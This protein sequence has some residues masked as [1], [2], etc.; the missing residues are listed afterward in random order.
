MPQTNII[1]GRSQRGSALI[2]SS[3]VLLTFL[4][5]LIGIVDFGQILFTHQA[6]VERTR[7]ALRWAVVHPYDGTGDQIASLIMYGQPESFEGERSG[8][9]TK[10]FLGVDRDN[11]HVAYTPGTEDDPNDARLTVSIVD[12]E[13][14]FFSPWIA[15][16]FTNNQAVVETA[17]MVYKP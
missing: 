7:K 6:M 13:F 1:R 16:K 14:Q 10:G 4:A 3:L 17:A 15:K 2:E 9:E 12:Y 5:M 11:V 8:F